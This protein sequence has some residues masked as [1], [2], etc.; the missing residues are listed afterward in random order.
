M[1]A[2]PTEQDSGEGRRSS[3][4]FFYTQHLAKVQILVT[5]KC[6]P[7]FNAANFPLP[8]RQSLDISCQSNIH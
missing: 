5:G 6:H 3:E 1:D 2:K 4:R 8:T 7:I